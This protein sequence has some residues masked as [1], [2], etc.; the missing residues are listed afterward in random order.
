MFIGYLTTLKKP[1]ELAEI[2]A[3]ACAYKGIPFIYL[4]PKDIVVDQKK[5]TGRILVGDKW[6]RATVPLPK[7][8]DI[9]PYCFKMSPDKLNFLRENS[10]L[11]DTGENRFNKV[12][13][14]NL[15]LEDENFKHLVIP[16]KTV[17]SL[18]DIIDYLNKYNHTI[19]KP[20]SGQFGIGV[21]SLKKR[22]DKYEL[23]YNNKEKI[24]T[25]ADLLNIYNEGISSKPYI[26]QQFIDS[27]TKG[28]YPFD[29][30]INMEKNDQGE[31]VI[32]KK[33]IRIGINQKVV[34][35]ISRGGG[36]SE[37]K[38]FLK[39]NFNQKYIEIENKLKEIGK[40]LPKK[41]EELR[42]IRLVRMG[43]D[44]GI[45]T[46]G[47]VFLFEVNSSPGTSQLRD[48]AALL[49]VDFYSYMLKTLSENK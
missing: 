23:K 30:R 14:Q 31:W 16:T 6:Q 24:I 10:V 21:I 37:T 19:L 48:K 11:S 8:I 27:I 42:G 20:Q 44:L 9:S 39:A 5:V 29:C 2:I 15:L 3:V 33:F 40:T 43:I 1:G 13:L 18:E 36:V 12:R 4:N 41:I 49:R 46:N 35:N 28:G 25:Y 47:D 38:P 17:K 34:S 22:G 7:F 26:I 32:A 45:N